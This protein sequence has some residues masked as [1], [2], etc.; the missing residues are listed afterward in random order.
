MIKILIQ[1]DSRY[2]V[3]RKRIRQKIRQVLRNKGIKKQAELS[4]LIVGDRKMASLNSKYLKRKGTTD[5]LSFSLLEGKKI[6]P[7]EETLR[8]GDIV[9][10]YP[11]ARKQAGQYNILVDKEI[12]RLVEHGLLHLLGVHH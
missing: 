5:V 10:S 3:N 9:I 7:K 8:L 2:P 6:F 11:Q 1:A 12:D 4:V